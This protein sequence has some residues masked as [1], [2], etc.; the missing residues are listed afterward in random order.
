M[1]FQSRLC[2]V[3]PKDTRIVQPLPALI[4]SHT[5]TIKMKQS[6]ALSTLL[7]ELRGEKHENVISVGK[8]ATAKI[9]Y[10][11]DEGDEEV[12]TINEEAIRLTFSSPD[13]VERLLE[14]IGSPQNPSLILIDASLSD[15]VLEYLEH[16]FNTVEEE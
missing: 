14:T 3:T 11:T 7:D 9:I 8:S 15:D 1:Y 10:E 12:L 5:V 4:K 2:V 16:A 13:N 6:E